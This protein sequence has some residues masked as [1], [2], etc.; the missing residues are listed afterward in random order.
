MMLKRRIISGCLL[1]AAVLAGLDYT[2][3]L[4]VW[5]TLVLIS[6]LAQLEFY[7]MVNM[8]DVPVFRVIGLACG[9]AL[10]SAT[11]WTIGPEPGNIAAA[12]DWDVFVLLGCLIVVFVRQFPQKHNPNPLGTIGCTL[13]GIWYVPFLFNF[14]TRLAFAWDGAESSAGMGATGR[15]LLLYLLLVVKSADIAAY[16]VGNTVGRHKLFPRIS[17]GKTWE[18]LMGGIAVAMS[19]SVLFFKLTDGHFGKV[20]LTFRDSLILG[21]LLAVAG[22]IGDMFESLLK[23]ASGT[24][25]S[26]SVIPGM[27]GILDVID[28][29]LFGAPILYAYARVFL[30]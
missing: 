2:P 26:G 22:V 16:F 30:T 7:A 12:Y 18:G 15:M 8:R 23:R 3:A 6:S 20:V 14:F 17:P 10:I 27:G 9:A 25:D 24:K 19:A 5:L 28:S 13:L 4:G 11:F 21:C 29:L 1:G